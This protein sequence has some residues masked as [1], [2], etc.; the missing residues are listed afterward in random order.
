MINF[1]VAGA[2]DLAPNSVAIVSF[3]D[4]SATIDLTAGSL[5]VLRAVDALNVNVAGT[6]LAL[7]AGER[8]SAQAGRSADDYKDA[9]GKCI[10]ADKDGKEECDSAATWWPWALVM[11]GAAVGII[12]AASQGG[13]DISLGGGTTVVSPNR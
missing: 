1:G 8:A 11:G 9:S 13:N 6:S 2:I 12:W 10:D 5:T 7:N 4:K 3:D